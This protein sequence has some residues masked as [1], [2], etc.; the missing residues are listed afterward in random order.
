MPQSWYTIPEK[1]NWFSIR[2]E[3]WNVVEEQEATS[4]YR[5]EAINRMYKI[6]PGY[7]SDVTDIIK[8]MNDK[9]YNDLTS[10]PFNN[11]DPN[12][13][14]IGA[15][16]FVAAFIPQIEYDNVSKRVKYNPKGGFSIKFSKTLSSILGFEKNSIKVTGGDNPQIEATFVA[17]L[18]ASVNHIYVY[19]DV[20]EAVPVGDTVAPLL[21]VVEARSSRNG[22]IHINFNPA[23]YL[24]VQKKNFDTIELDIRTDTGSLVPFEHGKV[25]CVL[26]FRR[27][28]NNHLLG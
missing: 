25:Y 1:H 26:H 8:K 13:K 19:C 28:I 21:R 18:L 22:V 5:M 7:Y 27:A 24:P 17:D 16:K 23:R 3:E 6:P 15:T 9:M 14:L 4:G 20:V 10:K 11:I 2:R 12:G